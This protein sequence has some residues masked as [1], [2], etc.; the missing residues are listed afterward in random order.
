MALIYI[1]NFYNLSGTGFPS[2]VNASVINESG[3]TMVCTP[4]NYDNNG[5]YAY[6][7]GDFYATD[8]TGALVPSYINVQVFYGGSTYPV[9]GILFDNDNHISLHS[10]TNGTT[11]YDLLDYDQ[12]SITVYFEANT[13][14][15]GGG[16]STSGSCQV[17]LW[18]NN[19]AAGKAQAGNVTNYPATDI[20]QTSS[21]SNVANG[22]ISGNS[23]DTLRIG[24]SLNSGYEIDYIIINNTQYYSQWV[25]LSFSPGSLYTAYIY[26]KSTVTTYT[27]AYN[28][29]GGSGAPS[30]QTKTHGTNLT[31]S[32]TIPTKI[33]GYTFKEWN[34]N[35]D[36][37]GTA[38]QPGGT[39]S[40]NASVTLYAIWVQN[41]W[42]TPKSIT[43]IKSTTISTSGTANFNR[44][45][46][47]YIKINT[48]SNAGKIVLQSTSEATNPDYYSYLS[49]SLLSPGN[50]TDRNS[51]VSGNNILTFDDDGGPKGYD[52]LIS[53][54][55][56]ASATYYWYFNSYWQGSGTYSMPWQ[57]NYY[58]KYQITYNINDGSNSSFTQNFYADNLQ[59]TISKAPPERTGYSFLGW[60]TSASATSAAYTA[61]SSQPLSAQDYILYGVWKPNTH[62]LTYDANGGSN[63]PEVQTGLYNDYWDL[64]FS[65]IPEN[66]GYIFKGWSP[67]QNATYP[68]WHINIKDS[69]IQ[70]KIKGDMTIYAVW[71][72]VFSWDEK[73]RIEANLFSQ[74]IGTYIKSL[75]SNN[76]YNNIPDSDAKYYSE[77][78]NTLAEDLEINTVEKKDQITE[79]SMQALVTAYEK[80]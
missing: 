63:V 71:W 16:S 42:Q 40:T 35:S 45:Q 65:T 77:W 76:T 48:P 66:A 27:V 24:V 26:T 72:P 20:I 34:T 79:K 51:A 59:V 62:T 61:G 57:Y 21:S 6:T 74:L 44:N 7:K 29:N 39:Y 38:Y 3:N 41:K 15:G 52:T 31:L 4:T 47:G 32:S 50:G 43:T 23:G 73:T 55:T 78:Y 18:I 13:S 37:T 54:D 12:L 60:S 9:N 14:S 8:P 33:G 56:S 25:N 67:H 5:L 10:C 58:R 75:A 68:H 22:Y 2:G 19:T 80:Y 1:S 70:L 11:T 49:S 53:Y 17:Q 30:S 69:Q 36:G 64:N 28:A 46:A